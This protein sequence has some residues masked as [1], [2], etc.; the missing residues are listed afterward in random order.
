VVVVVGV[1]VSCCCC[2]YFCC[3]FDGKKS[4]P[5]D[6]F[7]LPPRKIDAKEIELEAGD[8]DKG[9]FGRVVRG[10]MK[11]KLRPQDPDGHLVVV[12]VSLKPNLD[13]QMA[14]YDALKQVDP[15]PNLC[16]LVGYM[17]HTETLRFVLPF[18]GGGSLEVL[19]RGDFRAEGLG[20][21][22]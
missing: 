20:L 21:R 13:D 7:G 2:W 4:R 14:E 8:L 5:V 22:A 16:T 18:I 1:V 9:S 10:L 3:R 6:N 17:V 15:H 12:K 19:V 11:D